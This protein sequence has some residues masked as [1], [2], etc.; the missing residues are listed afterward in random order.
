[1][2]TV[3]SPIRGSP[4]SRIRLIFGGTGDDW[5]LLLNHDNG[6]TKWQVQDWKGDIPG[7]V[8]KQIN[9]CKAKG[10][11]VKYVDFGRNGGWYLNGEKPDGSAGHSWWGGVPE[12]AEK[13]IKQSLSE[14]DTFQVSLGYSPEHYEKT[15]VLLQ[16]RNGY[17]ASGCLRSNIGQILRRINNRKK[18]V[19]FVR[20]FDDDKYFISDEEGLQWSVDSEYLDNEIRK[21]GSVK[22]I[23]VASD[24][25][26][27]VIKDNHYVASTG[28]DEALTRK[29]TQFYTDQ[30][31][32]IKRRND[33][34]Q[35]AEERNRLELEERA[36]E[37]EERE[38]ARQAQA[39][40]ERE[41]M[42]AAELA[43]R[44]RAQREAKE[45]D[46]LAQERVEREAVT[47]ISS[48]EAKL[49]KRFLD[50]ARDIKDMEESLRRRKLALLDEM[51]ADIRSRSVLSD[52]KETAIHITCVV[53]HDEEAN[54]A[55]VPCGHVC[56]C[57]TCSDICIR[58]DRPCPL[59][60][61]NIQNTM[62]IYLGR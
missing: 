12:Q 61:V 31:R 13:T 42:E 24:G 8:T 43:A 5:L 6:N 53:C 33:E 47:R 58:D 56:L 57:S 17:S 55:V 52:D 41:A 37:A 15:F 50:E 4:G 10:R 11:D 25:S 29:L 7:E 9:N 49:E 2:L 32:W 40:A 45:A 38:A 62:R 3:P 1:M 14:R 20:L 16:G 35:S 26:W 22:E 51:P 46:R 18:E 44:E 39:Q 60:R 36:R 48:L 21:P 23:A 19:N 34:I 54:F 59:C 30:R 27:L 28:V